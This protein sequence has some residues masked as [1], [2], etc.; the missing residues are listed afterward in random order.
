MSPALIDKKIDRSLKDIGHQ[1]L[2]K[3]KYF[4]F[5]EDSVESKLGMPR[6]VVGTDEDRVRQL[7]TRWERKESDKNSVV[8]FED[9]PVWTLMALQ[10]NEQLQ[11]F[12]EKAKSHNQTE[13]SSICEKYQRAID[14]SLRLNKDLIERHRI[15]MAQDGTSIAIKLYCEKATQERLSSERLRKESQQSRLDDEGF[16]DAVGA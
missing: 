6:V 10:I 9:D 4:Q 11:M 3:V 2:S 15:L 1:Q 13:L 14:V 16:K 8:S 7:L 5:E 12:I